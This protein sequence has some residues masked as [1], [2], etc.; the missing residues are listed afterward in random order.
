VTAAELA[1]VREEVRELRQML[2]QSMQAE[3]QR[4]DLLLRLLQTAGGPVPALPPPAGKTALAVPLPEAAGG[5]RT[6][7]VAGTV[8]VKGST[9][10]PIYV[11]VENYRAPVVKGRN[12]EIVQKDKQFSPQITVVPRGT[13]VYFPN[14]DRVAHNVFSLSKRNVFDI[15]ILRAGE[16]GRAVMMAEPGIVEVFCDIHAK[17]WAEIL[18]APSSLYA[19]VGPD[20]KFRLP[21]VP[22]GERVIAAWTAGGA[23]VRRTVN[24]SAG[25]VADARLVLPLSAR[26]AHNN[27]LGRPYENYNE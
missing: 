24:V 4:Y 19:K 21:N 27:K 13:A 20:G 7:T 10:Q 3:Q 25:G 17:M 8:E 18:V 26:A 16:K 2:I 1:K 9:E 22:P 11:F 14:T 5:P 6:G 12:V 23:P 15:G